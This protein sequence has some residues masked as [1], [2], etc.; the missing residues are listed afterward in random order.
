MSASLRIA[1]PRFFSAT[2]SACGPTE[3]VEV[4][5]ATSMR[6]PR[7]AN[8]VVFRTV[9]SLIFSTPIVAA[10]FQD[11]LFAFLLTVLI[12]VLLY[13]LWTRYIKQRVS[14]EDGESYEAVYDEKNRL[15]V[16]RLSEIIPWP[17]WLLWIAALLYSFFFL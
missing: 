16:Y 2:I 8:F 1:G 9:E 10:F 17:I 4:R 14:E 15:R 13:A 12:C 11:S 3:T 6:K 7:T 5:A